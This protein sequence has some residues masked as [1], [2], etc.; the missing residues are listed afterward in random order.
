[1]DTVASAHTPT[2][3]KRTVT[4]DARDVGLGG[5]GVKTALPVPM[6]G[7]CSSAGNACA[8]PYS[9][10]VEVM[11]AP[12]LVAPAID[13]T[14]SLAALPVKPVPVP[15]TTCQ[16]SLNGRPC[17]PGPTGPGHTT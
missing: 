11:T 12:E 8:T 2:L 15:S 16:L 5:S 3:T 6:Q 10:N 14:I 9:V 1:M 4:V 13:A 17:E 7:S